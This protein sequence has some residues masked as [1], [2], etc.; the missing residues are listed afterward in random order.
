MAAA[1]SLT[2]KAIARGRRRDATAMNRAIYLPPVGSLGKYGD[3]MLVIGLLVKNCTIKNTT[4]GVRI[5][6]WPGSTASRAIPM[7]PSRVQISNVSYR[8]INGTSRT[9]VAIDLLCSDETPCRNVEL[10]DVRAPPPPSPA[11]KSH[12][13]ACLSKHEY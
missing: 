11:S 3:E 10:A 13:S 9:K 12:A 1:S 8:R 7:Q 5:K 2:V 6:T 4:N